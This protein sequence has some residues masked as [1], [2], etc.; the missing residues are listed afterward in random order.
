MK[1]HKDVKS[2]FFPYDIAEYEKIPCDLCLSS[3]FKVLNTKDRN[4]LTVRTCI[5][6]NCGLIFIN[7]RMTKEWHAKYY[8][9]EYRAQMARFKKKSLTK[10]NYDSMFNNATKHGI[11]LSSLVKPCI[12]SGLT[13]EVGSG[14]GGVLNGFKNNLNVEVLGIEPSSDEAEY[15]TKYGI[16]T[17]TCLIEDFKED[18]PKASNI[19][20]SQSLNHF[21][22]PRYFFKWAYANLRDEGNLVLEVQNFRHVFKH[23][24]SMRRAIQIDHTFMLVPETLE[25]FVYAAGF[26]ILLVDIDENKNPDEIIMQKK[27]GLPSF[28]IRLVGKKSER[29]PFKED[30]ASPET[31]KE[32]FESLKDIKD[33]Y[34]YYFL[35]FE[36]KRSLKAK[37]KRGFYIL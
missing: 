10:P 34:L 25:R 24:G 37:I 9:Y 32:I 5:C 22:S 12:A 35:K 7:P 13:I 15:A 23:F 21:L 6:K 33:S 30:L 29:K 28:H 8:E 16:K 31:Y 20:C 27:T 2:S 1:K 19:I 11:G 3:D 14:V 26:D 18:I 4:G 36:F 17:Y